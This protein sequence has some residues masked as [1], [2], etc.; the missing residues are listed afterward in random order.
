[1]SFRVL[2]SGEGGTKSETQPGSDNQ[3]LGPHPSS[4]LS[5]RPDITEDSAQDSWLTVFKTETVS[6]NP[7]GDENTGLLQWGKSDPD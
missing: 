6:Q 4:P 2:F 7:Q 3:T 5:A 1:M